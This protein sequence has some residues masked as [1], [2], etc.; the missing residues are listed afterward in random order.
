MLKA[1]TFIF[2]NG[3][4]SWHLEQS[5]RRNGLEVKKIEN[6]KNQKNQSNPKV[7]KLLVSLCAQSQ[8]HQFFTCLPKLQSFIFLLFD[9]PKRLVMLPS[10][11]SENEDKQN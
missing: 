10:L 2:H 7:K 6:Q 9:F 5:H 3:Q 11:F 8:H 4:Q 1:I